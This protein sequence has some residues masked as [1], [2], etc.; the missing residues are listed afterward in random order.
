M[1]QSQLMP[2]SWESLCCEAIQKYVRDT[3]HAKYT[4]PN[5]PLVRVLTTPLVKDVVNMGLEI[6]LPGG[7]IAVVRFDQIFGTLEYRTVEVHSEKETD[8]V[9]VL[10]EP[11]LDVG[12]PPAP[13]LTAEYHEELTMPELDCEMPDLLPAAVDASTPSDKTCTPPEIPSVQP[14]KAKKHKASHPSDDTP[15]AKKPR[16][17][18]EPKPK[19][20]KV[21]KVPKQP[22]EAK[23]PKEKKPRAPKLPKV[24]LSPIVT[25][26]EMD[27]LMDFN[28]DMPAIF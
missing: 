19:L 10:C 6:R 8:Q 24:P 21:P 20:T 17:P 16:Q 25:P 2:G 14:P 28:K 9:V 4:R 11:G 3:K 15:K 7:P 22:K 26:G 23:P 12:S 18:K 27:M 13:P 1:A 5:T